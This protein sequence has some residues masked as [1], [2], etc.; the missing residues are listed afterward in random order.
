[1]KD[2]IFEGTFVKKRQ[3]KKKKSRSLRAFG[4]TLLKSNPKTAR[5]LSSKESIHLVLK[6]GR[7]FGSQSMLQQHN[8]KK[9][10]SLIRHQAAKCE[11]KIYHLVNVGNHLHLIVKLRDTKLYA[12]FIRAITGLIARH[13]LHKERGLARDNIPKSNQQRF[14]IARPF[15]RLIAWGRDYDRVSHYME[16]NK[17]Q[18][19]AVRK[20][21]FKAWGFEITDP[22]MILGLNS[23]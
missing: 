21:V 13:V 19:L 2:F 11:I 15:T 10:E 20:V 3:N 4:G 14:W 6:S 1:M 7:A 5:P 17:N 9:I 23:C 18:S 16:K 22:K 8:V 12:Q